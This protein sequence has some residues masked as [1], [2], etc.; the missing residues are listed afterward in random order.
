MPLGAQAGALRHYWPQGTTTL[1]RNTLG[2]IGP[3]QPTPLSPSYTVSVE[4]RITD[5][6]QAYVIDPKLD[7]CHRERLPHVYAGDRLCLYTPGVGDWNRS[8]N[9]ALT[10]I[11]WTAEWLLHYEIWQVTDKWHGG[12]HV[13]APPDEDARVDS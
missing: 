10:I 6:P 7:P 4:Y 11:P 1:S 5:T 9:L 12:G 8:M 13:Y 2:W 3:L